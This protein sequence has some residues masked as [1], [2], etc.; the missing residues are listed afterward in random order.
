MLYGIISL[1][2]HVFGTCYYGTKWFFK[3][4]MYSQACFTPSIMCLMKFEVPFERK[5]LIPYMDWHTG[6]S[7][8]PSGLSSSSLIVFDLGFHR[9]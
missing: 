2:S 5:S 9:G 8:C 3:I 1:F 6:I 7:L 4:S